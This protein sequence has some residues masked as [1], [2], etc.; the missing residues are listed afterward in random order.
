VT[1]PSFT[2]LTGTVALVTGGASGIGAATAAGLAE[3]GAIVV[4]ADVQRDAG[5]KV[6][7]DVGGRFV[8]LDVTDPDAWAVTVDGILATEGRLDI[9][10]LN[11]GIMTGEG[12]LRSL[13]DEQ[14]DRVLGVNVRGVVYGARAAARAMAGAGGGIVATASV[15]G[16]IGW[17]ADPIYTLSKHAV[18]GLVRALDPQLSPLGISVNAVCPGIVDTDII[19]EDVKEVL[20]GA[21]VDLMPPSDIAEGVLVALR[22]GRTGSCF[23]CLPGRPAEPFTFG[24]LAVPLTPLRPA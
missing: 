13:T 9:A 18:V 8:V 20:R 3:E 14:L 23:Q 4:V 21:G 17:A 6:A 7:A 5:E 22:S 19:G 1:L 24:E 10:H 12:D 15:A 2:D 16:L 11:A